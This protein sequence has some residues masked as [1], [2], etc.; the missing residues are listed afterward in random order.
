MKNKAGDYKIW[1]KI[2]GSLI[3]IILVM[4]VFWKTEDVLFTG[5]VGLLVLLLVGYLFLQEWLFNK[6]LGALMLDL[7]DMIEALAN[8]EDNPIFST[9]EDTVFS[10]L[11]NQTIKLSKRLM[12][13]NQQI[14]K[15]KNE[16]KT[17][18]SD[19]AHQLKTPLSNI[20]MYNELLQDE[21]LSLE[22]K[23][24]FQEIVLSSVD[25][26]SFLIES[27]I[28][29]SR[30]E[31]GIIQLKPQKNKLNET[32]QLSIQSVK[33]KLNQQDVRIHFEARETVILEYDKL[34]T[35][36]AFTNILENGIKYSEPGSHIDIRFIPFEMF[37]CVTITDEGRGITE[38]EM[39]KI[40]SRFYRGQQ[41][42]DVEG[43]GIGL[44]LAREIM[45]K[46]GGYIKAHSVVGKGTTFSLFFKRH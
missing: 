22:E 16:I 4:L 45:K 20:K 3:G 46:Q 24:A 35:E 5:I 11:Q 9:L 27:L 28:K 10:K 1:L 6:Y 29:M 15:E 25:K 21:S 44:F 31:S 39:P 2:S 34:W 36:E 33:S 17:L 26:L 30:L 32:V 14:S 38:E 19:T 23:L 43:V 41:S 13:Q 40:F 8:L 18:I 7:S 12:A 37:F 42:Q